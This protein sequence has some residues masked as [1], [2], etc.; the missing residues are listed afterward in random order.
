MY[1]IMIVEDDK[2]MCFL[3]SKM[4]DWSECG[5]RISRIAYNGKEALKQLEKNK[6]DVVLTD[7]RMPDMDGITLLKEIKERDISVLTVLISSHDEF[8]YARQ[9]ILLGAFDFLVKPI[10]SKNLKEMLWRLK[11]EID[12]KRKNNTDSDFMQRVIQ[13][14]DLDVQD[15]FIVKTCKICIDTIEEDTTMD[16][17]AQELKLSK[18]YFGKL[19]KQHFKMPFKDLINSIKIEYAKKLIEE[20]NMKNY[21]ISQLLGYSTPDYFTRKFKQYT[22]TTPSKYRKE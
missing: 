4:K 9:G 2:N 1:K 21:E 5:F 11:Q 6:Y 13:Q 20:E 19:V 15:D 17:Y 18:D 16:D 8:E 22:G 12:Q 7:I 10:R 3:Y 14:L